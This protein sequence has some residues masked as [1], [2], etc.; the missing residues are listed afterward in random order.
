MCDYWTVV[1]IIMGIQLGFGSILIAAG[2]MQPTISY[3]SCY[4]PKGIINM[5]CSWTWKNLNSTELNIE[6][7]CDILESPNREKTCPIYDYNE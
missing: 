3:T 6:G 5:W 7:K 1:Y 2:S 4:Q